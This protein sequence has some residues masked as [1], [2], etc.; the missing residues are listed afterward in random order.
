MLCPHGKYG[1]FTIPILVAAAATAATVSYVAP[2]V[3]SA[4]SIILGA[5]GGYYLHT[6]AKKEEAAKQL[7]MLRLKKA[8]RQ[9][10]RDASIEHLAK[11]T[12]NHIRQA[13]THTKAVRKKIAKSASTLEEETQI[14]HDVNL[15][16]L[17]ITALLDR[18]SKALRQ[19]AQPLL[20]ELKKR[21]SAISLT[22]E[23]LSIAREALTKNVEELQAT[24]KHHVAVQKQLEE[25]AR[26]DKKTI[27]GLTRKLKEAAHKLAE[28]GERTVPEETTL[29]REENQRLAAQ[30]IELQRKERDYSER[31]KS[32]GKIIVTKDEELSALRTQ[33]TALKEKVRALVSELADGRE[34]ID[35]SIPKPRSLTMFR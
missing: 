16:L 35:D 19:D 12:A 24:V 6:D 1:V 28:L 3:I 25:D 5:L 13:N 29:L 8:K 30:V 15:Q 4:S 11:T 7:K 2:L 27:Q 18:V 20:T 22:Q 34:E 23:E 31:L 21:L 10:K 9:H 33:N 32:A 14:V 17:D 26:F